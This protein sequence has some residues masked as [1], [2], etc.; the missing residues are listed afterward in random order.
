VPLLPASLQH[1]WNGSWK[2]KVKV[3]VGLEM[4]RV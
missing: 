2:A 4:A 3:G 1:F